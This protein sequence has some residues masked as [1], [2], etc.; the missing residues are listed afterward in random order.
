MVQPD[1]MLHQN[2]TRVT[3]KVGTD[4]GASSHYF[5]PSSAM[6]APCS[7]T[8]VPHPPT[9]LLLGSD[10]RDTPSPLLQMLLNHS[11][12]LSGIAMAPELELTQHPA[13]LRNKKFC[14]KLYQSQWRKCTFK[15]PE[16]GRVTH[17]ERNGSLVRGVA[18]GNMPSLLETRYSQPARKTC[19]FSA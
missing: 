16:S 18:A 14:L 1:T 11:S 9:E 15:V 7:Y 2:K 4:M 8:I 13:P 6:I 10:L 19:C 17:P 3:S 5:S 12:W